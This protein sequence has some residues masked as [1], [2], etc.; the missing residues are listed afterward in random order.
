M[1]NVAKGAKGAKKVGRHLMATFAGDT[2][3]R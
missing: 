1:P 2:A 3:I